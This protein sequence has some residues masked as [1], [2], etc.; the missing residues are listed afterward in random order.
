MPYIIETTRPL[1]D[2]IPGPLFDPVISRRAVATLEEVRKMV[3]AESLAHEGKMV[4]TLIR[5]LVTERGTVTLPDGAAIEVRRVS[6]ADVE[7]APARG[8]RISRQPWKAC[9]G[10]RYLGTFRTKTEAVDAWCAAYN[11]DQEV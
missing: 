9:Y 10:G 8:Q 2:P 4:D 1:E 11:A 3:K 5:V 7:K 6:E